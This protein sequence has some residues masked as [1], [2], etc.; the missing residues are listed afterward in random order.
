MT[1]ISNYKIFRQLIAIA[2]VMLLVYLTGINFI[3]Y[4]N[5]STD[6][7]SYALQVENP[8]TEQSEENTQPA[9]PDEKTPDRPVSISEEFLHEQQETD[10]L[11]NE[12]LIHHLLLVYSKV[13][14]VHFDLVT[15]PPDR[16]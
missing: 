1:G 5:K 16:A 3:I 8:G 10:I 13:S 15:P 6:K 14:P 11:A 2:M 9:G 12:I 7:E 4:G